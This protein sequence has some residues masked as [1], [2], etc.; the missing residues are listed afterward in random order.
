MCDARTSEDSCLTPTEM[1]RADDT[2]CDKGR[3]SVLST[4]V[5]TTI[6]LDESKLKR[7]MKMAGYGTRNTQAQDL[8]SA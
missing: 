5:K 6:D 7:V 1:G 4:I 3:A 2:D 8:T